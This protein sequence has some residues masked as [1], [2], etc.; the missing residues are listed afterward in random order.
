MTKNKYYCPDRKIYMK[1]KSKLSFLILL[2]IFSSSFTNVNKV[3]NNNVTNRVY[4]CTSKSS[5]AYHKYK[6]CEFILKCKAKIISVSLTVA[7]KSRKPC[8]SCYME[9]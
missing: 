5:Y 8:G 6:D 1:R 7:Q 9:E 2:L 4:I 3:D